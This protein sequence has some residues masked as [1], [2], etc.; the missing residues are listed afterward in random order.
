MA[1]AGL[2]YSD[3]LELAAHLRDEVD[4]LRASALDD[5][6]AFLVA[7]QRLGTVDDFPGNIVRWGQTPSYLT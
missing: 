5:A 3:I 7:C 4:N 2:D 6:E 1:R